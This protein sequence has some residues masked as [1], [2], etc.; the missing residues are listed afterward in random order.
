[1]LC[2]A[3]HICSFRAFPV[4]RLEKFD[5]FVTLKPST[6]VFSL[7]KKLSGNSCRCNTVK[8]VN[9]KNYSGIL[10]LAVISVLSTSSILCLHKTPSY[11]ENAYAAVALNENSSK[12]EVEFLSEIWK[13]VDKYYYDETYSGHSWTQVWK[14]YHTKLTS[15]RETTYKIATSM[16]K[17][18]KD[19]YSTVVRP[20]DFRRLLKYDMT[21]TGLLLAPSDDGYLIVTG[22]PPKG[23]PANKVGVR[24]GDRVTAINGK[25]VKGMTSIEAA[26]ALQGDGKSQLVLVLDSKGKGSEYRT[27]TLD[28]EYSNE[29]AISSYRIF[30]H[31]TSGREYR[32]GYIKIR[33]FNASV[34]YKLLQVV[35][36]L[37]QQGANAYI[38]D[39]QGNRGGA[40]EGAFQVAGIFMEHGT[41]V[42]I[43]DRNHHEDQ[44]TVQS[45]HRLQADNITPTS[46]PIV[47]LTDK[48]SASASE[49]LASA[50]HDNCRAVLVGEKT[51]GKGL[52]QAVFGL[53]DGGG[54]ILTVAEYQTPNHTNIHKK[55]IEPDIY[56]KQRN[57]ISVIREWDKIDKQLCQCRQQI[58]NS[59]NLR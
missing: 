23:S 40:L 28:R 52:V 25:P 6:I 59:S 37:E 57:P 34:A 54:L 26:E 49:I 53:S 18:L 51:F 44:L 43:L 56:L 11:C 16:L 13:L 29:N 4:S 27:V 30:S 7:R 55:G 39:L 10:V 20:A 46:D 31:N 3:V 50:L 21:G 14:E 33:E 32:I 17:V 5:N 1:M 47:I 24:V 41:V 58:E 42:R 36:Y 12:P 9:Q 19:P 2:F 35:N 22:P 38:L 45:T 8:M 48:Y 15:R